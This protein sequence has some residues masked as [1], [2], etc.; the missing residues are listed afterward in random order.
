MPR[1]LLK[2]VMLL[3]IAKWWGGVLTSNI[4]NADQMVRI[5]F[6]FMGVPSLIATICGWFGR[7]STHQWKENWF[8]RISGLVLLVVLFLLVQGIIL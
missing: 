4:S 7:S 2:I 6:V 8:T 1:G 3:V 5:G